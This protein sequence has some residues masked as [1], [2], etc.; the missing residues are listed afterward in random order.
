[1]RVENMIDGMSDACYLEQYCFRHHLHSRN[2]AARFLRIATC[3]TSSLFCVT[4]CHM[5]SCII[6]T[7]ALIF[8]RGGGSVMQGFSD[9]LPRS[10]TEC[11]QPLGFPRDR[12]QA[13]R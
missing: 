8:S 3:H 12:G 6:K 4:A 9:I 10:D 2:L 11:P 13:S 5:T 7:A 1:M